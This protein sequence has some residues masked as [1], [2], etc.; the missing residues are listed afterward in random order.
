MRDKIP[1]GNFLGSQWP[2]SNSYLFSLFNGRPTKCSLGGNKSASGS[3]VE[4]VTRKWL[5]KPSE[6]PI[7]RNRE[8]KV[9]RN[10]R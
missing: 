8:F 2:D 10:I 3:N 9:V 1:D 4:D 5:L 7:A 6:P